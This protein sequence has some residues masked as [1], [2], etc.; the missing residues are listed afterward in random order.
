MPCEDNCIIYHM[1][2]KMEIHATKIQANF[3][4]CPKANVLLLDVQIFQFK[5][6]ILLDIYM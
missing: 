3:Q 4:Y 6:I 1:V 2:W 5:T